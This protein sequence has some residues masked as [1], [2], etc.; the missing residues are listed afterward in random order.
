MTTTTNFCVRMDSNLKKQCEAL[1]G[2]LGITLT[3]AINVFLRQ[4]LRIGGFPFDVRLEQ[5]K[6]SK[7]PALSD[8][9]RQARDSFAK[10]C[11]SVEQV[12]SAIEK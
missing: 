12:L 6:K 1:Y 9:E 7:A 5:Q 2:E 3:S 11:S 8:A 4:S 10:R